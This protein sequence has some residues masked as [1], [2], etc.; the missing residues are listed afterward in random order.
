VDAAGVPAPGVGG[1][2]PVVAV[3][4]EAGALGTAGAQ[5]ETARTRSPARHIVRAAVRGLLARAAAGRG[6]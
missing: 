3:V 6:A 1:T 5:P 4:F 2:S